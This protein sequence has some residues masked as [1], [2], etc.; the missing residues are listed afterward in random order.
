MRRAA[1]RSL[2]ALF[3]LLPAC[4]A[5]GMPTV[6][7]IGNGNEPETLDPHRVEGVSASN[8]VRDLYEGLTAFSP[9]GEVIAGAAERWQVSADGRDYRFHLRPEARWSDGSPLTAED[10]VDG[11]RRSVAPS[12]G[13]A[14]AQMLSLIESAP[15]VIAGSVPS[16]QLGVA[17]LDER[18]LQILLRAPAP[19]LPGLLAH[20]STFPIHRPSLQ[21]WGREFARP[22]RLVSNG[23]YTLAE[24]L[25]QARVRL[26]R[27]PHY[28]EAAAV[29]IAA[30]EY[31]PSE[32]AGSELKR[33]RADE[34]DITYEVP[35]LQAPWLRQQLPSE[36]RVAPYLGTYFYGFNCA[37]P[38]FRGNPDLR[39]AL[40]LAVDRDV[41]VGKVMNG[42]ARPAYNLLPPGLPGHVPVQPEW[43]GWTRERRLAEARRRYA[44]AGYSAER[45]LTVE[46]RYN[47]HDDHRRIATVIAAM[48]KQWLGVRTKLVNEEFK[49][50][51]QNR[52]LR[53]VTQLFRAAWIADFADVSAFTDILH[54]THGQNDMAYASPR[55]DALL[56]DAAAEPDPS[57]RLR[58]LAEAERLLQQD[59]P[60]L[61]IYTYVSKHLVKPRVRGWQD[62]ALDVHYSKDLS[63]APA[64]EPA[65]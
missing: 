25:P 42:L 45:P 7:R 15:E 29:A 39:A 36:L 20:P 61:P 23:A 31:R 28:R 52:N 43:A 13:S 49:V 3:L 46:L 14:Y 11:L 63:L 47:T 41:I 17:A 24:W 50:F 19:Q 9:T 56:A 64:P 57:A 10:F 8:I 16:E 22:G 4:F 35:L 33:Y 59:W 55:Y 48:W 21:R 18:T 40:T 58:T 65:R 38:P 44:A 37:R 51:I 1:A 53:Q 60:V 62:N 30:V 6:L 2:A 26:Q 5:W 32:D 34:L 27:N 12:T 54:S